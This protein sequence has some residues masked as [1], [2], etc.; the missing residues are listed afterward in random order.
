MMECLRKAA[1]L[2]PELKDE[3]L[4]DQAFKEYWADQEFK[5]VAEG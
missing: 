3:A 4:N 1:H 2:D 5:D